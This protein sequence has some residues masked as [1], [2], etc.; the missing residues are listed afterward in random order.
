MAGA[1]LPMTAITSIEMSWTPGM[2]MH[3]LKYA[4]MHACF[5]AFMHSCMFSAFM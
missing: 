4:C 5:H 3:V 2:G 1:D